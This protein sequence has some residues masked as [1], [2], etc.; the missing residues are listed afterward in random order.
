M[1]KKNCELSGL[2]A[3][4]EVSLKVHELWVLILKLENY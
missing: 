1:V 4:P 2:S 3:Q